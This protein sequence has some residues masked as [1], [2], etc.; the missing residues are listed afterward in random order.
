MFEQ[1][2]SGR[3]ARSLLT[4]AKAEGNEDKV[5][6]DLQYINKV[7]DESKELKAMT[8]SPV[9]QHWRKKDVYEEV[10]KGKIQD[11]TLNF[12]ILLTEKKREIIIDSIIFQFESQ[13]N[14][15]KNR[16]KVD[17]YTAVEVPSDIR[18]G[19]VKRLAEMTK[20]TILPKYIT[21]PSIKGGM[22]VRV[23]DW[24]YD[25]SLKSQLEAL[26]DRLAGSK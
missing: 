17:I 18:E 3:Y 16:Q 25:A 26:H 11:I 13:Y 21:E 19:V 20:K 9:I 23:G 10:F 5:Y 22:M 14:I 4:A 6:E 2:V 24:V 15:L 1:K 7:L 8:L 12:L